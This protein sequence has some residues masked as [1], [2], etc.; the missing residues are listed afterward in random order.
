MLLCN[1]FSDIPV[2]ILIIID[3][4]VVSDEVFWDSCVQD[5]MDYAHIFYVRDSTF[6]VWDL[7]V[8]VCV[9]VFILASGDEAPLG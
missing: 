9:W 8:C 5:F 2:G 7:C 3:F 1:Y 6:H 4:G